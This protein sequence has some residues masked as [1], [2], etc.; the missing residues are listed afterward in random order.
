M[1]VADR[2]R[3]SIYQDGFANTATFTIDGAFVT[4]DNDVQISSI[5]NDNVVVGVIK[6]S[7]N[8]AIVNQTGNSNI[9][10]FTQ[11]TGNSNSLNITQ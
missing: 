6:S 5:G 9:A 10:H 7:Y 1:G 11:M 3:V 8:V 4:D 2:N